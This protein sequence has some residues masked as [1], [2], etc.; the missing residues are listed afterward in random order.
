M[1]A[2][3]DILARI[4][5]ALTDRPTP[6]P[7]ERSYRTADQPTTPDD[8]DKDPPK[9][10]ELLTERL[11]DYKANVEQATAATAATVIAAALRERAAHR[12]VVPKD[13][14]SR[15]LSSLEG[16]QTVA[17]NPPLT[18]NE[19]DQ[20][21][22]VLTLSRLA[23]AETGTIVL[24]AGPGQGRRAL[25]LIPDYHLCVVHATDIIRG[26]PEAVTRLLTSSTEVRPLTWISGPSATSDIELQRV[27][28]VH[29]PRTLA[30]ILI[31]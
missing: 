8:P 24:D 2:K 19:L 6:T 5:Q 27:E 22:G 9:L 4:Q 11:L 21:D 10:L 7:A 20:T 31:T 15:L 26:V 23:I 30:V 12:I 17:D 3:S 14:P 25:S 13:F 29:G 18:A 28:G 1:T 16:I